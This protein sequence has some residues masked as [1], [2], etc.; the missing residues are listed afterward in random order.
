MRL[1][2]KWRNERPCRRL[3][4]GKRQGPPGSEGQEEWHQC[5]QRDAFH[6]V[7]DSLNRR[8]VPA[9]DLCLYGKKLLAPRLA[10]ALGALIHDVSHGVTVIALLASVAGKFLALPAAL[11]LSLHLRAAMLFIQH[12]FAGY[13]HG[14]LLT[15]K[16]YHGS[17]AQGQGMAL[18]EVDHSVTVFIATPPCQNRARRGPRLARRT[19]AT[20]DLVQF[21]PL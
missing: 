13:A 12:V 19:S 16:P 1:R 21:H 9:F 7:P 3:A 18:Q 10:A 8:W 6:L 15:A 14:L 11:D 20:L 4:I 2:I 5:E 17:S